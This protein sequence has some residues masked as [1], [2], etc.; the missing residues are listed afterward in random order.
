[1]AIELTCRTCGKPYEPSM[2]ELLKG[3]GT[4][5]DCPACRAPK[6]LAGSVASEGVNDDAA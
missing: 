1:M 5:R 2:T 3:P 4:Y 6:P